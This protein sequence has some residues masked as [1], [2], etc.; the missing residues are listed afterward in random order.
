MKE[1][2][3]EVGDTIRA[4]RTSVKGLSRGHVQKLVRLVNEIN[5]EDT[6]KITETTPC[7]SDSYSRG[8]CKPCPGY[9]TMQCNE[10]GKEAYI[11]CGGRSPNG[12]FFHV[13]ES[14][15]EIDNEPKE[16]NIREII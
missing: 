2:E 16:L 9:I 3:W 15:I 14:V 4:R 13:M 6:Y 5:E 11:R 1:N 8:S 12:I 10:T 7:D